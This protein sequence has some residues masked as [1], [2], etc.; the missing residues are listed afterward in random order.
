MWW[1]GRQEIAWFSLN[2]LLCD[3]LR[4]TSTNCA[5]IVVRLSPSFKR[6]QYFQRLIVF[7]IGRLV[8][9]DHAQNACLENAGGEKFRMSVKY[10]GSWI[11]ESKSEKPESINNDHCWLIKNLTA[12]FINKTRARMRILCSLKINKLRRSLKFVLTI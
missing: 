1:N 7:V 5:L 12:I 3:V 8:G 10:F 2:R 11:T 4:K 9:G 6:Y